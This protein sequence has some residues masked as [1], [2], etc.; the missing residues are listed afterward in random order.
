MEHIFFDVAYGANEI[1]DDFDIFLI[2]LP[3]IIAGLFFAVVYNRYR[4]ISEKH[5]YEKETDI[6]LDNEKVDL[7]K[8]YRGRRTTKASLIDGDNSSAFRVRV[9]PW[10]EKYKILENKEE[11][12]SES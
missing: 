1:S 8:T 7:Q 2:A 10:M 5:E 9:K 4:S 11:K 12:E 3:F 6:F